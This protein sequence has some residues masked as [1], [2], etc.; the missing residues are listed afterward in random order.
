MN[1]G[2]P[3][4]LTWLVTWVG[5]FLYLWRIEFMLRSLEGKLDRVSKGEQNG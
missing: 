1:E 3:L 2:M 5:L 4:F